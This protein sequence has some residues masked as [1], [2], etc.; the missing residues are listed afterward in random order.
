[1]STPAHSE[2]AALPEHEHSV[3]EAVSA[4]AKLTEYG[5]AI[6]FFTV[7][8]WLRD[9]PM[10]GA[11]AVGAFVF[12]VV[13]AIQLF[14]RL[15]GI[16]RATYRDSKWMSGAQSATLG[17]LF[18]GAADLGHE[19]IHYVGIGG[20]ALAGLIIALVVCGWRQRWHERRL[21]RASL[22]IPWW[23]DPATPPASAS[24]DGSRCSGT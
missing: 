3:P 11:A 18:A 16:Q 20:W 17:T 13:V 2:E 9:V 4:A 15:A 12:V 6:A 22:F 24:T 8:A 1:M 10:D 21:Y 23:P 19:Y 7:F 14:S 5:I